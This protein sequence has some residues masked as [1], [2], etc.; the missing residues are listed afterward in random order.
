MAQL[1]SPNLELVGLAGA[2]PAS[3][4]TDRRPA[5]LSPEKRVSLGS[6][7]PWT[8]PVLAPAASDMA[9]LMLQSTLLCL[10]RIR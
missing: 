6:V 3:W 2:E 4:L 5:L 1:K 9:R 7:P 8:Y 10:L